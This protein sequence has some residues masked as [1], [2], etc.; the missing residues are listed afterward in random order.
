M[1]SL[2]LNKYKA[3]GAQPAIAGKTIYD[4][5]APLPPIDTQ[6][7]IVDILDNFERYT[8]DLQEGLPAEIEKRKKQYAYY[9]DELL[10]FERKKKS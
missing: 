3:G 5:S 2:N 1:I 6:K 10:R 4:L 7:R 9:R 8:N